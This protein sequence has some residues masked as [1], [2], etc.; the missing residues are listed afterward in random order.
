MPRAIHDAIG[1]ETLFRH[2]EQAIGRLVAGEHTVVATSTSSG[3]TEAFLIPMLAH[4]LKN[5]GKP[6][7]KAILVY[8]MNAL[9]SDQH[10]RLRGYLYHLNRM[11]PRG[12]APITIGRYVGDTPHGDGAVASNY[13]IQLCPFGKE[14]AEAARLGCAAYCQSNTSFRFEPHKDGNLLRCSQNSDVTVAFERLTRA[15]MQ[16][17]P[18]DIL[19]TNYVQLE[20]LLARREDA[21]LFASPHLRYFALDEIHTYAG[22]RGTEVALLIRRVRDRLARAGATDIVMVGTSAT[23]SS[24]VDEDAARREVAAFAASLFGVKVRPEAVIVGERA[25]VHAKL[26]EPRYRTADASDLPTFD[27]FSR[28]FM[29]A[30]LRMAPAA[31]AAQAGRE[32][33]LERQVGALLLHER[34]FQAVVRA[35]ERPLLYKD[36]VGALESDPT[37][38]A[39]APSARKHA[40]WQY[41]Q[42]AARADNPALSSARR[43]TPLI[44]ATVHVFYRSVGEEWPR[45][46]FGQCVGCDRLYDD[47]RFTCTACGGPVLEIGSCNECGA[48]FHRAIYDQRI[49]DPARNVHKR[50][51]TDPTLSARR[52]PTG[53]LEMSCWSTF[54]RGSGPGFADDF[55]AQWQCR[56]CGSAVAAPER[57]CPF[58]PKDADGHSTGELRQSYFRQRI[59]KCPYCFNSVGVREIVSPVYMSPSVSSRVVFDFMYTHLPTQQRRTLIFSDSRQ[60]AAYVAGTLEF[61]HATHAVRQLLYQLLGKMRG[62]PS[63]GEITDRALS[64]MAVLQRSP[65]SYEQEQDL[66]IGILSEISGR[67]GKRR[68]LESLGL[69]QVMYDRLSTLASELHN[70]R[71]P[72][73]RIAPIVQGLGLPFEDFAAFCAALCYLMKRDGALSGLQETRNLGIQERPTG[74]ILHGKPPQNT[75]VELK[76]AYQPQGILIRAARRFIGPAG[77]DHAPD[78]LRAGLDALQILGLIV[79]HPIGHPGMRQRT[80][81]FVIDNERVRLRR[82]ETIWRCPT[83]R[84]VYP[85]DTAGRCVSF[86]CPDHRAP[87]ERFDPEAFYKDEARFHAATFYRK[88]SPTRLRAEEDTGTLDTE[89]R[90]RIETDF[91]SGDIDVLVCTPTMELGVNIGDLSAVGLMK[92]PP[93]PANYIQRAGRAGRQ[94]H[95]A[96]VATFLFH[97]RIDSHYFDRPAELILGTV[98]AGVLQTG[99][100]IIVAKHLRAAI[101]EEL[102]VFSRLAATIE[103]SRPVKK[104]IDQ[105]DA[106]LV[107]EWFA[108]SRG[109]L[110]EKL[111][112]GFGD[113]APTDMIDRVLDGFPT[114]LKN[115]LDDFT[116]H[117]ET[118]LARL[119]DIRDRQ[120]ELLGASS[121]MTQRQLAVLGQAQRYIQEEITRQ[122]E[123]LNFRNLISHFAETGVIPRYAFPGRLIETRSMK[124]EQLGIR[125]ASVAIAESPPG[126]QVFLRKK[127]HII[128][129]VDK[130]RQRHPGYAQ[131]WRCRSCGVRATADDPLRVT[132]LRPCPE[133][134]GRDWEELSPGVEP[135][136]L[137][138]SERGR[139]GDVA[140]GPSLADVDTYVLGE[141]AE[142]VANAP[143]A[144]GTL[145]RLDAV[146]LLRV[147]HRRN[148][149]T[150][151]PEPFRLCRE[152]GAE[153]EAQPGTTKRGRRREGHRLYWFSPQCTGQPDD[154][155]LFSRLQTRALALD[156]D[157]NLLPTDPLAREPFLVSLKAALVVAAELLVSAVPG[158]IDA[159]VK[160]EAGQILL[161]DT[162][163]GG[164]GFVDTLFAR[165]DELLD[166]AADV[167]LVDCT[168]EFGCPKCLLS[169]RRR[170]DVAKINKQI[171]IGL[172]QDLKRVGALRRLNAAKAARLERVTEFAVPANGAL[173]FRGRDI[174]SLCALPDSMEGALAL[175]DRIIA[176][177]ERLDLVSLYASDAP[178]RWPTSDENVPW[179]DGSYSWSDIL[180]RR[181]ARGVRVRVLVRPP[182]APR[183]RA[184]LTRLMHGGVEVRLL[185]GSGPIAHAKVAVIDPSTPTGCAVH[186][187]A[188]LSGETAKN[189]DIYD[190]GEGEQNAEWI[191]G[192]AAYVE[193]LLAASVPFD[194]AAPLPSGGAARV[195][196]P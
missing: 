107:L 141:K 87:L 65:L 85:F 114:E 55:T 112:R 29:G 118:L 77:P 163:E 25:S 168:C 155:V 173:R 90:R 59:N 132:P 49:Q 134:Q 97:D 146:E 171:L 177:N 127:E 11:L 149:L 108:E 18:P 44:Q 71:G 105:N 34:T 151:I 185:G 152:C 136:V 170:G 2:Q 15:E 48:L 147:V 135:T 82:P 144:L 10:E 58:C 101:L 63:V 54:E 164:A 33:T 37:F 124:M 20:Y 30:A 131:F 130:T 106:T 69:M 133:C 109:V 120:D 53:R 142:A 56:R 70:G 139:P 143:S 73:G 160:P 8:P 84:S 68:A 60:E 172:A 39:L 187:S 98:R 192:T 156:L 110:R 38:G 13:P 83:C 158:E 193:R 175:R 4:C 67:R 183:E 94:D 41:L 102:F 100:E 122:P 61:E 188:N 113:V 86:Y 17:Q 194:P 99:N 45:G 179:P 191:S 157:R 12:S 5:A 27:D 26:P 66:R 6:G 184:S 145:T 126:Q 57:E 92:A 111:V 72:F 119:R 43:R 42:L 129:G 195:G 117:Y 165:I 50:A 93:S 169:P 32:Q 116:K 52:M 128:V 153:V 190:F 64:E 88:I 46:E 16:A 31:E 91:K 162:V 1:I 181:A 24:L 150:G 174:L 7:V 161:F 182:R 9:A 21:P 80:R 74:Y 3:K 95:T 196:A 159:E 35:L 123:G 176:A 96:L 154:V 140:R 186:M 28:D 51:G 167:V 23:I 40:V 75:F 104:F 81:A 138:A 47:N 19:I 36:L 76:D 89:E 189:A 121:P 148:E 14:S 22:V 137:V 62:W 180:L 115:S 103:A 178:L 166:R 125:S 79:E 78:L